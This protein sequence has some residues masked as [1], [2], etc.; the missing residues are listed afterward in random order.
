VAS[1]LDGRPLS[2]ALY[3]GDD[4]TDLDAFR[5]LRELEADGGISALCVG[6]RSAEGPE[7]IELEAD[8]VVDGT[9]GVMTM[10]EA[11]A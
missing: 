11:L 4:T 3:A 7:A 10:L 8:V 5:K 6:V 2:H 1:A 9:E